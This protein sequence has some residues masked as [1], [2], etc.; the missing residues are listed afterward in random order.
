MVVARGLAIRRH[1]TLVFLTLV[2]LLN[3]L[4][5]PQGQG[6]TWATARRFE[7]GS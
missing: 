2:S 4:W 1:V 3:M 7:L 6:E 5:A